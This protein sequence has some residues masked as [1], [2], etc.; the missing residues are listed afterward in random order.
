MTSWL[1][2]LARVVTLL[3]LAVSTFLTALLLLTTIL[4]MMPTLLLLG[5]F[6]FLFFLSLH[7]ESPTNMSP[8][9]THSKVVK[10]PRR[11]KAE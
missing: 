3:L 6:Q 5:V 10:F 11:L 7:F 8:G 4:L 1:A 9:K 2:A